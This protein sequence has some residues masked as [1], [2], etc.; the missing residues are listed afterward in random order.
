MT[1]CSARR[2]RQRPTAAMSS[3]RTTCRSPKG[4]RNAST[5]SAG[6]TSRSNCSRYSINWRRGRRAGVMVKAKG[7][8]QMADHQVTQSS[9][10]PSVA[11]RND[12]STP[13]PPLREIERLFGDSF[14]VFGVPALAEREAVP[15][16]PG[17]IAPRIDVS[18]TDDEIRI[19]AELRGLNEND[20]DVRLIDD[21]L[22][23]R[24]A[25][26]NEHEV[27]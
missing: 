27:Q 18:E 5:N 19:K 2:R 15:L 24:G 26:Q 6:S 3:N 14:S 23:I 7:R 20:V 1:C 17:I 16:P 4:S 11:G 25:A 9:G 8:T 13:L 21:V 12:A 10:N 22:T